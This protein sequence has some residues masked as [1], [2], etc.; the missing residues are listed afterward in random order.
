MTEIKVGDRVRNVETKEEVMVKNIE[1]TGVLFQ[2]VESVTWRG[3]M[4]YKPVPPAKTKLIPF[5]ADKW[6]PEQKV[7][8]RTKHNPVRILCVDADD[9]DFPVIGLV[10]NFLLESWTNGGSMSTDTREYDN[11]LMVVVETSTK[12][13]Y[14]FWNDKENYGT[15]YESQQAR[16]GVAEYHKNKNT[17]NHVKF[18]TEIEL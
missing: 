14:G 12:T 15:V 6:T 2:P 16:D 7:V 3:L 5:Q 17:D 1:N 8:T 9:D 13:L 11:D 18:Q 4:G 10:E